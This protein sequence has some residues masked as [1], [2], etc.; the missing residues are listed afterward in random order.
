M[1]GGAPRRPPSA[2]GRRRLLSGT[3]AVGL[4]TAV[5]F[6]WLHHA[7]ISDI[8]PVMAGLV[9]I[10]LVAGLVSRSWW[11]TALAPATIIGLSSLVGAVI[12][13]R[14]CPPTHDDTPLTVFMLQIIY[15]GIPAAL[16]A[17]LGTLLGKRLPRRP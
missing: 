15:S 4:L 12:C 6:A 1:T 11:A 16:G 14:G 5:W 13:A 10:G 8:R 17:A 7:R 2:G 3:L 9:V